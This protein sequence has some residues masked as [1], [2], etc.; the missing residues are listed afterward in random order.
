[1]TK[2]L[3]T[4]AA[5]AGLMPA[6]HGAP[7]RAAASDV[8]LPRRLL[9]ASELLVEIH[10][11]TGIKYACF[12]ELLERRVDAS[13][14]G[15]RSAVT[16]A[17]GLL[18]PAGRRQGD[19]LVLDRPG[20]AERAA[21]LRR[22]FASAQADERRLA[23]YRAGAEA[24][25]EFVPLLC[26]MVADRDESVRHHALRALL[27]LHDERAE[28]F[29]PGRVSLLSLIEPFPERALIAILKA[30]NDPT[31]NEWIWAATLL[32]LRPS[33]AA[34]EALQRGA[35]HVYPPTARSARR[36]L[37]AIAGES[38]APF[39]GG[40]EYRRD[41]DSAAEWLR[42]L[43]S[44]APADRAAA[45]R[46]LAR[47]VDAGAAPLLR[48][49]AAE[50]ERGVRGE[51]LLALACHGGAE[52]WDL[53]LRA[54][55]GADTEL[56]LAALRGLAHCPD[57]RARELLFQAML[58]PA[59]AGRGERE[60]AAMALG[61][62]ADAETI[63]RLEAH[64]AANAE[65]LS[66]VA[67]ALNAAARPEAV[68]A[69]I[70]CL[71]KKNETLKQ[72]A[73]NGLGR[74]GTAAAVET[75]VQRCDEYNNDTRHC[76]HLALRHV[77][78][79]EG[80]DRLV[81]MGATG[82]AAVVFHA[83]EECSDPRAI[84]M[85]IA[86]GGS[87]RLALSMLGRS[88]DPRALPALL[89]ALASADENVQY[90]AW[91][92]L[93]WRWF[94]H[95]PE[96][97]AAF[98][99][100]PAL[101]ALAEPP[102]APAEQEPNTWACRA[103]PIDLDDWRVCNTT[104]E[105]GV[106]YD[107]GSGMVMRWG[108]HGKRVDV[109]QLAETWL[110]DAARGI[111]MEQ[112]PALVPA[113][114]CGTVGLS[115]DRAA[116]RMVSVQSTGG[117][118]GWQWERERMLRAS[119]PNIFDATDGEWV[120][121][122][123]LNGPG[124]RKAGGQV[125]VDPHQVHLVFAGWHGDQAAQQNVWV[126]DL[127]A[128]AWHKLPTVDG[129]PPLGCIY[130]GAVYLPAQDRVL[131]TG[132]RFAK[133]DN[134]TWFY[135][136]R[137]NAWVDRQAGGDPPKFLA[138][139]ALDPRSGMVLGFEGGQQGAPAVWQYD[140]G[141]NRWT[142]LPAAAGPAPHHEI[143]D[144][145]Y[146]ARND[147]F[148]IHGGLTSWDSDSLA[149]RET[150]SYKFRSGPAAGSDRLTAPRDVR[151]AVRNGKLQLAWAAVPG[152]AA[153]RVYRGAAALPWQVDFAAATPDPLHATSWS[154]PVAPAADERRTH[155]YVTALGRDG[156]EGEA[157]LRV[158]AQPPAPVNVAACIQ[159]DRTVRLRWAAPDGDD[160]DGYH[161]YAAAIEPP[162]E[163]KA[164]AMEKLGPLVRLT[165][166]PLRALEYA[167]RRPL[168]ATP[169]IFNHEVRA[170]VVRTVNALGIEG[171]S[172]P[173]VWSLPEMPA[174]VTVAPRADGSVAVRWEA[175]PDP[176]LLGYAVYRMDEMRDATCARL[177]AAPIK[178]TEL[179]D[180]PGPDLGSRRRYYVVALDALGC[181]GIPSEG[182]WARG[183]P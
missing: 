62:V 181:E 124:C 34:A 77:R 56:R 146:D 151:V 154:D 81:E 44:G 136:L 71:D 127:H 90:A 103:W 51:L 161:V 49:L 20:D 63:A 134:R 116:R 27:R 24:T 86:R 82:T 93:R 41:P 21:A 68:P 97:R 143:W 114:S 6:M 110:F 67:L 139:V 59:A 129:Q 92:A 158:R 73:Y 29:A 70:A 57:P 79:Q 121:T 75:M 47:R 131:F 39:A 106:A 169:G 69:L 183:R 130:P 4:V 96:V 175:V 98:R 74:I 15:G 107:E 5:L 138:G 45:A 145:C 137:A 26:A 46:V 140:V 178:G 133:A 7:A 95:R 22:L 128:N 31:E 112:H 88:G 104:Y 179:L 8:L 166:A 32:A 152:A 100:H 38:P 84:D 123:A 149:V 53:L 155:Y 142:R 165:E 72:Y 89:Q 125:Y 25:L 148:V 172:S 76:A 109:P 54:A 180:W 13:G 65:P 115:Y 10:L 64:V 118:H 87:G 37:A 23:C 113:G 176:G 170:Y 167:D 28:G 150:W 173:A 14:L 78:N 135:D 157:S 40:P 141:S 91:R 153:Y 50:T 111:W 80:I 122:R 19:I 42:R 174:R 177:N 102:P 164:A 171:G 168:E 18:T 61:A 160:T 132:G 105:A 162:M 2:H 35:A 94:W 85:T 163:E 156:R 119:S 117:E 83:L 144:A 126:Y 120:M 55:G 36:A 147:L 58:A 9:P 108:A 16:A 1:M 60:V 99:A 101:R 43:E 182:A 33:Q 30:A 3:A 17:L 48:A 159:P 66:V 52:A 11:Q 12:P